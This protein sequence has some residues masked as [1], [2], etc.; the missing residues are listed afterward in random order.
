LFDGLG[1]G[2][3]ATSRDEY[4]RFLILSMALKKPAQLAIT[5]KD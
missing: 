5:E 1:R 3:F 2:I 4:T